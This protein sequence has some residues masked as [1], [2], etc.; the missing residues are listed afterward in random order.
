MDG[1]ILDLCLGDKNLDSDNI[2]IN[3][4]DEN[5]EEEKKLKSSLE[6]EKTNFEGFKKSDAIPEYENQIISFQNYYQ[7]E[8]KEDLSNHPKFEEESLDGK[9]F[10]YLANVSK[11][12]QDKGLKNKIKLIM[13]LLLFKDDK[14]KKNVFNNKEKNELLLYW[15][16]SYIKELED[17]TFKE[18]NKILQQKLDSLDPNNKIIEMSRNKK[19]KSKSHNRKSSLGSY[20]S[21]SGGFRGSG[22]FIQVNKKSNSRTSVSRKKS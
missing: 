6:E 15:K 1:F 18:K 5:I 22:N 16:N 8:H 12:I 17:A 11:I 10:D 19:G 13:K 14:S 4:N 3:F 21:L 9:V 20:S 2:I 7:I